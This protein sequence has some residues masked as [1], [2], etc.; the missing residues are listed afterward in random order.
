MQDEN[1]FHSWSLFKALFCSILFILYKEG[2]N[3]LKSQNC[4]WENVFYRKFI[5][6]KLNFTEKKN[7]ALLLTT[8]INYYGKY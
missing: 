1:K 2:Y 6:Q 3:A 5:T 7:Q 4:F 8:V